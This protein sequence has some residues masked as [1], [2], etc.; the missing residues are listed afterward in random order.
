MKQPW[1]DAI[2]PARLAHGG[3]RNEAVTS[4]PQYTHEHAR[5]GWDTVCE[6]NASFREAVPSPHHLRTAH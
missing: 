1:L 3:S 4:Q 6:R 2:V 5:S